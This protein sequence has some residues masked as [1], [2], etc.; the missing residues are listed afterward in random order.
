MPGGEVSEGILQFVGDDGLS[1]ALSVVKPTDD[2][3]SP[4][5]DA[6]QRVRMSE[7]YGLTLTNPPL[8]AEHP[9]KR[10]GVSIGSYIE[11]SDTSNRDRLV[12]HF[13]AFASGRFVV[14]FDAEYNQSPVSILDNILQI[15]LHVLE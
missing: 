9:I 4:A 1:I 2:S 10:N 8:A 11:V 15:E 7:L 13:G 12:K 5:S 6:K 14:V 3:T